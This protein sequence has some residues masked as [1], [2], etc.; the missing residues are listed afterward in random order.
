MD[1]KHYDIP[2]STLHGEGRKIS[3]FTIQAVGKV[4]ATPVYFDKILLR[5]AP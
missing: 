3:G 2:I 4:P 1:W 5:P